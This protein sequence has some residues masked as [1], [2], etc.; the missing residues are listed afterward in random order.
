[1]FCCYLPIRFCGGERVLFS[2]GGRAEERKTSTKHAY[3]D[4]STRRFEIEP[5]SPVIKI[6]DMNKL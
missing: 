6:T 3:D 2:L 1:M 4:Y 5:F